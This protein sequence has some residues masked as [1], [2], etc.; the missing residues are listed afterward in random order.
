V[1]SLV[2][3][4]GTF[5]LANFV[6]TGSDV[7]GVSLIVFFDDADTNNNRDVV[8]FDGNDSNIPFTGEGDGWNITLAGINYSSGTASAQFHVADGQEFTDAALLA[9]A[10]ELAPVGP[11]FQGTTVPDANAGPQTLWD[12]RDFNVTSLLSPGLNTL[13]ITTG[14]N[15]DCLACVLIALDLPAGA[16]PPPPGVPEPAS[17]ALLGIGLAGLGAMRRRKAS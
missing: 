7:N 14:V 15:S 4:N 16:A 1:S 12:I 13:N 3:G 5:S 9:N 10:T 2:S 11:V 17:L 6:K 8:M